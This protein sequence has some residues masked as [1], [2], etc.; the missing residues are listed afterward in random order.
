MARDL[1]PDEALA[2]FAA[3]GPVNKRIADALRPLNPAYRARVME[4]AREIGG[5]RFGG[6]ENIVVL[7]AAAA[8]S[9]AQLGTFREILN[10]RRW[11]IGAGVAA[12]VTDDVDSDW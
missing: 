3:V 5:E 11:S 10:G 4:T 6:W 9:G 12:P 2:K 1:W 7:T 8:E